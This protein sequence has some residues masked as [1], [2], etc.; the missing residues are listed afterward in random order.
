MED[1]VVLKF[2]KEL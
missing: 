1:S 2:T